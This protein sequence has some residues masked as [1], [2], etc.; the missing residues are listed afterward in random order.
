MS[1]TAFLLVAVVV[2]ACLGIRAGVFRKPTIEDGQQRARRKEWISS[3]LLLVCTA[4]LCDQLYDQWGW[5]GVAFYVVIGAA[6]IWFSPAWS[7]GRRPKRL[8]ADQA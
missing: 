2:S 6:L 5:I 4:G 1:F 7:W 3:S 8:R